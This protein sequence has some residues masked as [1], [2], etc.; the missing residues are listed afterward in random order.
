MSKVSSRD[1]SWFIMA[2]C[3][4]GIF[5]L[6]LAL[7]IVAGGCSRHEIPHPTFSPNG[8]PLVGAP[9]PGD[10][11]DALGVWFDRIDTDHDGRLT[12]VELLADA[13]RQFKLMDLR[14]DGKVTAEELSTYRQKVM[15]GKYG[16]Y[17]TRDA[18]RADEEWDDVPNGGRDVAGSRRRDDR[19]SP[20]IDAF[21]AMSTDE[22]DPV[23]S[24]DT[25][26]DGSVTWDEFRV[27]VAQ[28]F[29]DLD[30]KHAGSI[31]KDDVQTLCR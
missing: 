20:R 24:A 13:Q 6:S 19:P 31:T 5:S 2:P 1:R 26:L 30:K 8:E 4:I 28:N 25:D 23:M 18:D 9:W 7:L 17:S 15:G 11:K 14:H 22:P 10:C 21:A 12:L 27:L 3:K 29:A 16:V